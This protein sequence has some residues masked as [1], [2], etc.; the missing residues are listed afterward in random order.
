MKTAIDY[1]VEKLAENGIIHS[2]DISKAKEI[3]KQQII[4]AYETSHI[5][6]MTSKQY[7]NE[8]FKTDKG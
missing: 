8:T 2:F 7:Y 5:S 1:L 4:D 6:M 3:F